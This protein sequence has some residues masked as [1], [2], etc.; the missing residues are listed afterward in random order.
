[1]GDI[2]KHA[3]EFY[4][5]IEGSQKILHVVIGLPINPSTP[6]Y[7]FEKLE[8]LWRELAKKRAEGGYVGVDL[9]SKN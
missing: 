9:H 8:E 7:N 3:L 2:L 4:D 5:T 6:G 1:M